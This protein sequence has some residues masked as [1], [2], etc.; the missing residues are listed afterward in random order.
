MEIRLVPVFVIKPVNINDPGSRGI[1]LIDLNDR[2]MYLIR[3]I[4]WLLPNL[5]LSVIK[6]NDKNGSS[7]MCLIN[8]NQ[9]TQ[10]ENDLIDIIEYTSL[11]INNDQLIRTFVVSPAWDIFLHWT[12]RLN[13][14]VYTGVGEDEIIVNENSLGFSTNGDRILRVRGT[15]YMT[16]PYS[17]VYE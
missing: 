5:G 16:G 3:I 6:I 4:L 10:D 2:N 14:T 13:I 15:L 7:K 1:G 17:I 8:L 11:F 9:L 12:R